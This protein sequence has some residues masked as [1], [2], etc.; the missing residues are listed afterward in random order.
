MSSIF[1]APYSVFYRWVSSHQCPPLL[2]CHD[3]CVG[4]GPADRQ[5]TRE[6][7]QHSTAHSVRARVGGFGIPAGGSAAGGHRGGSGRSDAQ[8]WRPRQLAQSAAGY[9]HAAGLAGAAAA[10]G[11]ALGGVHSGEKGRS[12]GRRHSGMYM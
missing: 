8:I 6:G 10:A 2:P 11:R 5:Q 7:C 12:N 9:F 4:R 3:S 1:L